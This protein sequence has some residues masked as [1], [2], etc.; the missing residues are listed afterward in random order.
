MYRTWYNNCINVYYINTII[1]VL[2]FYSK[3]RKQLFNN[4][5]T[6]AMLWILLASNRFECKIKIC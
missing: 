6:C 5:R 1:R 2:V 4:S 3:P